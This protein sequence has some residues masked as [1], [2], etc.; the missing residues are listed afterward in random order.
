MSL[1]QLAL[2]RRCLL[3]LPLISLLLWPKHRVLL[4]ARAPLHYPRPPPW[5]FLILSTAVS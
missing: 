2:R 1:P 3:G 4:L 5:L